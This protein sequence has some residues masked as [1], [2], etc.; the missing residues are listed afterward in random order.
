[1]VGKSLVW[2]C[3]FQIIIKDDFY[4]ARILLLWELDLYMDTIK[5]HDV[6]VVQIANIYQNLLAIHHILYKEKTK[7][8]YTFY[9]LM[10]IFH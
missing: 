10:V 1:M 7:C 2:T 5:I 4:L 3:E 6:D 8:Y 9:S